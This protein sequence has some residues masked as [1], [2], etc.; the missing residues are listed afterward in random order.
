MRHADTRRQL[1]DAVNH[2]EAALKDLSERLE[3][4]LPGSGRRRRIARAKRAV[5]RTAGSLT[6]RVSGRQV[7]SLVDDTRRVVSDHP[8]QVALTAAVAGYCVWSLIRLAN[9]R[10]AGHDGA[11]LAD[12]F[13]SAQ[14]EGGLHH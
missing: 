3:D 7:S 13:R 4:A 9:G 12:R 2:V 8:V 6:D 1:D 5:R 10:P 11:S 14:G